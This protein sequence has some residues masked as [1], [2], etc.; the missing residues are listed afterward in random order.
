MLQ[1]VFLWI[2][3]GLFRCLAW[4]NGILF[5]CRQNIKGAALQEEGISCDRILI[6]VPIETKFPNAEIQRMFLKYME[7][8]DD[9]NSAKAGEVKPRLVVKIISY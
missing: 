3:A 6:Q 9:R 1:T 4:N 7:F 5:G 8:R 2:A